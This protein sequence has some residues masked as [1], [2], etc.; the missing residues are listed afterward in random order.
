MPDDANQDE[1]MMDRYAKDVTISDILY[2]AA[3]KDDDEEPPPEQDSTS[4]GGNQGSN[5][6]KK[7]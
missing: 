7:G 3:L 6:G 4:G 2:E 1:S 5:G